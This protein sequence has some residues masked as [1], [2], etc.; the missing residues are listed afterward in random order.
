MFGINQSD[1]AIFSKKSF[2]LK[3][4]ITNTKFKKKS[5]TTGAAIANS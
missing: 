3:D 1:V 5:A 4:S 2:D